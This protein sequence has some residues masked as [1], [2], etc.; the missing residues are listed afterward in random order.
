MPIG[1]GDDIGNDA[2][3][4]AA[5]GQLDAFPG[6]TRRRGAEH[7]GERGCAFQHGAAAQG[8][9]VPGNGVGIAAAHGEGL[10]L[11]I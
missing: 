8:H 1:P 10:A 7:A 11:A 9:A 2:Q 3:Q 6:G 4:L 5:E